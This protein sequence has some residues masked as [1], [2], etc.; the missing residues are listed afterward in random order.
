MPK[1]DVLSDDSAP[2]RAGWSARASWQ[3]LDPRRLLVLLTT[4]FIAVT[5]TA[6]GGFVLRDRALVLEAADQQL[7]LVARLV[8]ATTFR[9]VQGGDL[10]L[11][12]I[13]GEI[14]SR[15]F[16]SWAADPGAWL[17]LNAA[18]QTLPQAGALFVIGADGRSV[19]HS[20]NA[21]T[22]TL[23]LG[24][25]DYFRVHARDRTDMP[26]IGHRVS[27]RVDGRE[28]IGISRRLSHEDGSFAGVIVVAIDVDY[29][30]R[31]FESLPL[32]PGSAITILRDDGGVLLRQAHG[33]PPVAASLPQLA[34]GAIGRDQP[35]VSLLPDPE[36]GA[37]LATARQAVGPYDLVVAASWRQSDVLS[38]WHH[39]LLAGSS[40]VAVLVGGVTLLTLFGL[41]SLRR[42][43]EMA[44]AL[45]RSNE[46]LERRVEVRTAALQTSNAALEAA[47]A[48]K[49]LLLHEVHHRVKNNLQMIEALLALQCS[50][51]GEDARLALEAAR[52]RINALGLVHQQLL[53]D[54]DLATLRADTFLRDLGDRLGLSFGAED[55]AI[56]LTVEAA[57][58]PLPLD[59]AIPL[60]LIVNEVLSNAFKHA[61]PTGRGGTIKVALTRQEDMLSLR[62]S[63]DGIGAPSPV[64]AADAPA[65]PGRALGHRI[66]QALVKQV[67]GTLAI[68]HHGGTC[69]TVTLPYPEMPS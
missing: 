59:L 39:R 3:S 51:V 61:F 6:W 18:A 11:R 19:A 13:Q 10:V 5:L 58:D 1:G 49:S 35:V 47:V 46:G 44:A 50:R 36:D 54:G 14:D 15:G 7:R 17:R 28:I 57:P 40:V 41:R 60:G 62:L 27:S 69:L 42:Q 38:A 52:R 4:V 34:T 32:T 21:V 22:P 25:R 2:A 33:R 8:T 56:T 68:D 23:F 43:E 53:G 20:T 66:V 48:E 37:P 30:D 55:R 31:F 45:R 9:T 67:K 65:E 12:K 16:A 63:D 29:F 64:E 24:D 26:Y